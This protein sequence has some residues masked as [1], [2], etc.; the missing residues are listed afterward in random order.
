MKGRIKKACAKGSACVDARCPFPHPAV[1]QEKETRTKDEK[2]RAN[3][4]A[5]AEVFDF[6]NQRDSEYEP[7]TLKGDCL[8]EAAWEEDRPFGSEQRSCIRC[9][10][11]FQLPEGEKQWFTQRGLCVP[12]RCKR[13]RGKGQ[14]F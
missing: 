2:R 5:A 6:M 13:C 1:A 12:K 10:Q 9:R 3:R 8:L 4:R 7:F 14:S 11:Y